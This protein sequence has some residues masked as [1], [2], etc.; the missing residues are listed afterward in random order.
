MPRRFRCTAISEIRGFGVLLMDRMLPSLN[1][2][3]ADG[4]RQGP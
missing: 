4:P 3:M 1:R 2:N